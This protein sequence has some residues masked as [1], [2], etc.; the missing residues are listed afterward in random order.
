[1]YIRVEGDYLEAEAVEDG[2][3]PDPL[4]WLSASEIGRI[5][6]RSLTESDDDEV[7]SQD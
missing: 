6:S 4:P 1:M 5:C 2:I 3:L 7:V